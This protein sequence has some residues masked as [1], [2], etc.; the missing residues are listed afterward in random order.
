M[1]RLSV[2][3]RGNKPGKAPLTYCR[4]CLLLNSRPWRRGPW[5]ERLFYG[6]A[7]HRATEAA[8]DAAYLGKFVYRLVG[9]DFLDTSSGDLVELTTPGQVTIHMARRGD[10][11]NAGYAADVLP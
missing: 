3:W 7:V 2:G 9:P 1:W 10:Y 11:L 5:R 6:Q 4:S 8:L